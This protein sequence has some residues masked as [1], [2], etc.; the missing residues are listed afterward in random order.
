MLCSSNGGGLGH[1][2]R[3]MAIA[4]RLPPSTD[5]VFV[6][7]SDALRLVVSEGFAAEYIPTARS[8]GANSRA[9]HRYLRQRMDRLVDRY[10]PDVLV[11]DGVMP[12]R[13]LLDSWA[14]TDRRTVWLRRAMWRSASFAPSPLQ[15][16]TGTFDVVLEPGD[17]AT[18]NDFGA[19]IA[20][21][22]GVRRMRPIIHLDERELLPRREARAALG[23]D[24][25]RPAALVSL[26][27]GNI[28]DVDVIIRRVADR[29]QAVSDVVP[30]IMRSPIALR[31][32]RGPARL[33]DS[34]VP[35]R[36]VY[37]VSRYVRAFDVAFSAAGY[38]TFHELIAFAVPTV[39]VPN[40]HAIVDD[41]GARARFA[42]WAGAALTA[43]E[44][45]ADELHR[46]IDAVLEPRVRAHLATRCRQLFPGNGAADAA[47]LL[48]G[49]ATASRA[50][51]GSH[52]G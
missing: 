13:G 37:P 33:G 42:E 39:F 24:Q 17:I 29:L 14:A 18:A 8:L 23:L 32:G 30:V 7:M 49:L 28:N 4:R 51:A 25:D 44:W 43:S 20:H 46:R 16:V 21:V 27:A 12:Y 6:T 31:R 1:L 52:G 40:E 50:N 19:T 38:N 22:R 47:A 26:G 15:E 41:Q 48:A 3:L 9:W 10:Q 11:F 35:V 2:T 5:A 36:S 45:S 34:A